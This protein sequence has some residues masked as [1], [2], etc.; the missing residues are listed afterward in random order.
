MSVC[1]F[2]CACVFMRVR[3]FEVCSALITA[4]DLCAKSKDLFSL[5]LIQVVWKSTTFVLFWRKLRVNNIFKM[6]KI[7]VRLTSDDFA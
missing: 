3:V 7:V 1:V 6:Q 5:F 2:V 4:D